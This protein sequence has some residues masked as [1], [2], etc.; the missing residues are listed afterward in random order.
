[1]LIQKVL[2]DNGDGTFRENDI[3]VANME[4]FWGRYA[5]ASIAEGNTFDADFAKLREV[6]LSYSF[7]SR[8][9][10]RTPFGTISLGVEA[11]NVAILYSTIPHIDPEVNLFGSAN[12]GAGVERGNLPSTRS[13]GFNLRLTF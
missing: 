2:I 4:Q 9:L 13:I 8:M 10:E 5:N 12:D 1:L 7:P 11:R 3:P 6:G